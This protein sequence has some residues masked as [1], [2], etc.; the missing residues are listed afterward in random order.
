M[1]DAQRLQRRI[2]GKD[3]SLACA[4]R[5]ANEAT[6]LLLMLNCSCGNHTHISHCVKSN[7]QSNVYLMK[8]K[9][10]LSKPMICCICDEQAASNPANLSTY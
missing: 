1:L 8:V 7:S 4:Q 5:I 9:L 10:M 2:S 3:A 6:C